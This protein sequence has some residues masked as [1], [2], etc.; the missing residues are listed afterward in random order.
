MD[1]K[2]KLYI[3]GISGNERGLLSIVTSVMNHIIYAVCTGKVPVVDLKYRKSI[4]FKDGRQFRDNVWEYFFKQPFKLSL[5]DISENDDVEISLDS[6]FAPN[7]DGISA[8]YMPVSNESK[9]L[10]KMAEAKE[11]YK[12]YFIFNDEMKNYL[13]HRYT[14]AIGD[15][16]NILGVLCR[17]TD[18]SKRRTF[19]EC[20]QPKITDVIKK[21]GEILKK[22]PEITKIYLATEDNDIYETFKK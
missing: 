3:V 4:Y 6:H 19:A 7:T 16:G 5:S 1:I 18:Y 11:N 21:T 12:K 10:P 15:C 20:I 13:E 17:G 22:Y 8:K 2:R 9:I 14:E